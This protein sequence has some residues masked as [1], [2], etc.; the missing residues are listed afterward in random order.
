MKMQRS[1]VTRK[2]LTIIGLLL[3][4]LVVI[5]MASCQDNGE[6]GA[7]GESAADTSALSGD[8]GAIALYADDI[9]L[10]AAGAGSMSLDSNSAGGVDN[11]ITVATGGALA[12]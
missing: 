8:A 6:E 5:M 10:E 3:I 12:T 7:S 1:W 4:L 9:R 11:A 2:R